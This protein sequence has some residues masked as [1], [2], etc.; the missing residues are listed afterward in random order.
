MQ[1]CDGTATFYEP[2]WQMSSAADDWPAALDWPPDPQW[3]ESNW[4]QLRL[5]IYQVQ[6]HVQ[7]LP[8]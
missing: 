5:R 2:D 3:T 1:G 6:V 4:Q 8:A 7:F